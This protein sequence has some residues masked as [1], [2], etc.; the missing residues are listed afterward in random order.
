MLEEV[1]LAGKMLAR[2]QQIV[3]AICHID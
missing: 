2:L 1:L 3:L